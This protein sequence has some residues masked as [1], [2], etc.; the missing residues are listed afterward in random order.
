MQCNNCGAKADGKWEFCPK[1]GNML[2]TDMFSDIFSRI[3]G[4]L[5]SLDD[6]ERQ[7]E[8]LDISPLFKK[9]KSLKLP[10]GA[11]GFSISISSGTGRQPHV[12]VQGFGGVDE[13]LL[14]KHV[15]QQLGLENRIVEKKESDIKDKINRKVGKPQAKI[16]ATEEPKAA[17]KRLGDKV[18]V[19]IELPKAK[20]KDVEI[21]ELES[22]VEVKAIVGNKAYFKIVTKPAQSQ[23]VEKKFDNGILKLIFA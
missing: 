6:F 5:G 4:E 9:G 15:F 8:A 12:S 20:G 7:I 18:V 3:G 23:I 1:C 13:N 19:E 16:V 2:K 22:S 11:T 10:D 14:K 17:V 21:N